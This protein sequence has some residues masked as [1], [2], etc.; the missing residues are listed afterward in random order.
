MQTFF[1]SSREHLPLLN[2]VACW[3]ERAGVHP[4]LW[5]DPEAFPAGQYTLPRL[6]ELAQRVEAAVFL[7]A[8]DDKVW[9][10]GEE[11]SQPRDNVLLEYGLFASRL[12]LQR[13]LICQVDD[14]KVATDLIGLTTISIS[15]QRMRDAEKRV[16]Q[17]VSNWRTELT[18]VDA[19]GGGPGAVEMGG[20]WQPTI[21][22]Q[23]T[24]TVEEALKR[25]DSVTIDVLDY[26]CLGPLHSGYELLFRALTRGA[27]MRFLF[28]DPA[29]SKFIEVSEREGDK[30]GRL[31]HELLASL[32][33]IADLQRR[34]AESET[35][36][37]ERGKIEIRFARDF[38]DW[39]AIIVNASLPDGITFVN[40]FSRQPGTR[41][42]ADPWLLCRPTK[43][44]SSFYDK[45]VR[46]FEHFFK[47]ARP[48]RLAEL[49]PAPSTWP[50]LER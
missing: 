9:Y 18:P 25:G 37:K 40:L 46:E 12:G 10:R 4:L 19:K 8:G 31:R 17:W 11:R 1:A 13:S 28:L 22:T 27:S 16:Q 38:P 21:L 50:I 14:S 35:P 2:D 41:G 42:L 44:S 7:F 45:Y 20:F 47:E 26:D 39:A 30:V 32:Y 34:I 3:A 15:S 23:A 33:I 29:C 36:Q 48:V 5:S 49:P 43:D 24:A 6:V